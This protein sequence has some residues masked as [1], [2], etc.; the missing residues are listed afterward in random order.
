M[1]RGK[2]A[3]DG[4]H[5]KYIRDSRLLHCSFTK[6]A[7][8]FPGIGTSHASVAAPIDLAAVNRARDRHDR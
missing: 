5:N 7:P 6:L 1:R 4:P 3:V 2:H 8:D